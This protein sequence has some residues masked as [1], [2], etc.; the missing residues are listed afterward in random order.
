MTTYENLS[1]KAYDIA[2]NRMAFNRYVNAYVINFD[3]LCQ[4]DLAELAALYLI[5]DRAM[6]TEACGPDNAMFDKIMMPSLIKILKC[7]TDKENQYDFIISWRKG[8]V[9][10][11]RKQ[12]IELIAGH[13]NALNLDHGYIGDNK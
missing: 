8:I 1:L 11:F 12:M 2:Q 5:H 3:A 4:D 13:L 9:E 10:Y 6:G 7:E